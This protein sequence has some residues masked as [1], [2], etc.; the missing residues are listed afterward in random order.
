MKDVCYVRPDNVFRFAC[1]HVLRRNDALAKIA[2]EAL[3][4]QELECTGTQRQAMRL[5]E[6]LNYDA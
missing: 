4:K 6:L 3:P 2:D 1:V 5:E